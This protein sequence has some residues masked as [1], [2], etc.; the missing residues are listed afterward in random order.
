MCLCMFYVLFFI[1]LFFVVFF[2]LLFY[3]IFTVV[4]C[5]SI[6]LIHAIGDYHAQFYK[7]VNILQNTVHDEYP[8]PFNIYGMDLRGH[9]NSSGIHGRFTIKEW[10]EDIQLVVTRIKQDYPHVP[11]IVI[12]ADMVKYEKKNTHMLTSICFSFFYLQFCRFVVYFPL[13]F[14]TKGKK[15]H[16]SYEKNCFVLHAIMHCLCVITSPKNCAIIPSGCC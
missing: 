4:F 10:R 16:A 7:L 8:Y 9:G 13:T 6:L 1:F 2:F 11:L 3:V 14:P 12:G 15:L 5:V